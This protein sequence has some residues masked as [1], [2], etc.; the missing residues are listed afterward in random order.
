VHNNHVPADMLAK[1]FHI[2]LQKNLS[3][4]KSRQSRMTSF[5][6]SIIQTNSYQFMVNLIPVLLISCIIY[7]TPNR[8]RHM[9]D[10]WNMPMHIPE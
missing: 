4:I 6:V 1:D 5:Y 9:P 8:L 7:P 3:S 2:L 10:I